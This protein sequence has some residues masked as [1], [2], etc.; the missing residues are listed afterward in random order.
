[1]RMP[2]PPA[3]LGWPTIL[4]PHGLGHKV[5]Y[6]RLVRRAASSPRAKAA[7]SEGNRYYV[8]LILLQ[9]QLERQRRANNPE[10]CDAKGRVNKHGKRRL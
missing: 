3:V 10:H 5:K 7:D 4:I 6:A 8:Q 2:R 9:R 1:M